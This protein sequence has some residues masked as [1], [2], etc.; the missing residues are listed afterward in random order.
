LKKHRKLK[1]NIWPHLSNASILTFFVLYAVA[2]SLYPGGSQADGHSTGFSWLNNYWCNLLNEKTM[3]GSYNPGQPVAIIAMVILCTGLGIF[4][5]N[6]PKY[7]SQ[8][9]TTCRIIQTSGLLAMGSTMLLF[10]NL[11]HDLVT[12]V[13]AFW[14]LIAVTGLFFILYKKK[15]WLLFGIGVFNLLLIVL[16]NVLYFNKDYIF[17][18]PFV[19]KISFVCI[20]GWIGWLNWLLHQYNA[21]KQPANCTT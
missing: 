12:S 15:A 14:G 6:F 16:N 20:L 7:L 3:N 13:A 8:N 2:A 10:S 17:Y 4:W 11:N 18:L 21:N 1:T 9:I 19:Q 5:Y